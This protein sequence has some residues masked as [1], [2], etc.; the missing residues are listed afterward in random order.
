MTAIW[1]QRSLAG[2]RTELGYNIFQGCK[3]KAKQEDLE[4]GLRGVEVVED[5]AFDVSGERG[6]GSCLGVE[7]RQ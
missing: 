3:N 5:L 7:L 2:K 4:V 1:H 6:E